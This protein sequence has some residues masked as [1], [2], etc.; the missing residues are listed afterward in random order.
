MQ[1]MKKALMQNGFVTAGYG[2][3]L[4]AFILLYPGSGRTEE[5]GKS[6]SDGMAETPASTAPVAAQGLQIYRDPQTGRIGAPPPGTKPLELSDAERRMLSRSDRGLQP[7]TLPGG[8]TAIHLQGRYRNMAVAT[9]GPG[10]QAA[11]GC[12][13][14]PAQ[15]EV[16]MQA[17]A[18]AAAGSDD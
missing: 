8:G 5:G 4:M 16:G 9:V 6:A 15:A 3:I 13:V 11:V 18:P 1:R 2:L 10:G 7:H 17:D 14:T 12:A